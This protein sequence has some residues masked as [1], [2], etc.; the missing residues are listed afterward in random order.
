MTGNEEMITEDV[1]NYV[2]SSVLCWLATVSEDGVPNVSPKEAFL[3]DDN[4]RIL[5]ANI[6]SPETVRNI[7]HSCKVCLSFVNVFIQ[8]GYKITGDARI[9]TEGDAGYAEGLAKLVSKIG[10]TFSILSIIEIQ[11]SQVD[12]IVAPSYRIFPDST[13]VDRIG[14]S[15]D[16]YA[17]KHYQ[18]QAAREEPDTR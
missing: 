12:P 13:E 16:S 15:L 17:V 7:R 3:L 1:A 9:L 5:V 6:A 18:D 2:E 14:E 11:P 8:K 10:D 4:G